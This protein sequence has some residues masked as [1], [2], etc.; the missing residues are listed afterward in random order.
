[1][2]SWFQ[3]QN[4]SLTDEVC[5]CIFAGSNFDMNFVVSGQ[6]WAVASGTCYTLVV[7]G[8]GGTNVYGGAFQQ[9]PSGS[10]VPIFRYDSTVSDIATWR[11]FVNIGQT[12]MVYA[13]IQAPYAAFPQGTPR[14]NNT[15]YSNVGGT[16]SGTLGGYSLDDS[17]PYMVSVAAKTSHAAAMQ[18]Y[19]PSSFGSFSMEVLAGVAG[20]SGLCPMR[21]LTGTFQTVIDFGSILGDDVYTLC[22]VSKYNTTATHTNCIFVASSNLNSYSSTNNNWAQGGKNGG[23]AGA[24]FNGGTWLALNPVSAEPWNTVCVVSTSTYS[25]VYSDNFKWAGIPKAEDLPAS[26]LLVIHGQAAL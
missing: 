3:H 15:V 22:T 12:G 6:G 23:Y 16:N 11:G 13:T 21:Y 1:M 5:G 4:L 8:T 25:L 7:T 10:N 17:C 26:L 9:T 14:V 19:W 20:I 24:V 18:A 2:I